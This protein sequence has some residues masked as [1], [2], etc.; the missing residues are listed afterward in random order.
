MPPW[1]LPAVT[2]S[3]SC[4]R[5]NSRAM[6]LHRRPPRNRAFSPPQ[7]PGAARRCRHLWSRNHSRGLRPCAGLVG[8]GRTDREGKKRADSHPHS[9]RTGRSCSHQPL[10]EWKH[11]VGVARVATIQI[12][13]GFPKGL[14]IPRSVPPGPACVVPVPATDAGSAP[15]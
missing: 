14:P 7:G 9:A 4:G 8:V 11:R 12:P 13:E 1:S 3:R 2:G 15:R 6:R 10:V 5:L